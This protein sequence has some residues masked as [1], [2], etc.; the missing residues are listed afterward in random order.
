MPHKAFKAFCHIMIFF[1]KF[2]H[3]LLRPSLNI[4]GDQLNNLLMTLISFFPPFGPNHILFPILD[5]K[6]LNPPCFVIGSVRI[7]FDSRKHTPDGSDQPK[8]C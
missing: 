8:S 6:N 2:N 4:L 3:H 1:P 5:N 7:D